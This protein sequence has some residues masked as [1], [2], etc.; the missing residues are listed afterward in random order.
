M[1]TFSPLNWFRSASAA[2]SCRTA[3]SVNPS[4]DAAVQDIA[5]QLRTRQSADLALVFVATSFAFVATSF[6]L[7][8]CLA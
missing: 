7:R 6:R 8:A 3:L 5:D 4:L 1:A 2:P